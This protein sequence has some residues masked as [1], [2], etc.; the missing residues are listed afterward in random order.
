MRLSR[1]EAQTVPSPPALHQRVGV[2]GVTPGNT[3]QVY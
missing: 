2:V 3:E 1:A